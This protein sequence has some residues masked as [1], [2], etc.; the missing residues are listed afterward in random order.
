MPLA[1]VL[2]DPTLSRRVLPAEA[3]GR[4]GLLRAVEKF[5][6]TKGYKFSTYG[7][8]WIRRALQG[9]VAAPARTISNGRPGSPPTPW[10]P[11]RH[12]AGRVRGYYHETE[13]NQPAE[14][15]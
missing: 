13:T 4:L 11:Q 2:G 10:H 14:I 9:G 12:P 3:A 5:D 15:Q 7:V 8:W 6:H 1:R